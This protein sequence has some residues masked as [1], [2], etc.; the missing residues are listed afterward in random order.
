[1]CFSAAASFAAAVPLLGGGAYCV[2][3]SI[4]GD[5]RYFAM[6]LMPLIIGIQQCLEG[7]VWIGVGNG[8][9]DFA[10]A[11]SMAYMLCVWVFWPSW[12]PFMTAMLEPSVYKKRLQLRWAGIGLI[13]GL[14]LYI[15]YVF[16]PGWVNPNILQQCMAYNT[17]VLPDFIMPRWIT[18]VIYLAIIAGAPLTSSHVYIKRFGLMLLAFVPLTYAL[19]IHAY[20]SVLCFFAAIVTVDL[21]YIISSDKCSVK[22]P[23]SNVLVRGSYAPRQEAS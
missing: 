18:S 2:F 17:I 4:K 3:K 5:R 14:V 9:I 22:T 1:M 15:P 21:I 19:F 10:H 13:Y 11:A 8:D 6:A 20:L 16:Q 7:A 12:V 23:V